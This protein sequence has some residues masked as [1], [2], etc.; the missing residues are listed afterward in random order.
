MTETSGFRRAVVVAEQ[1]GK[2]EARRSSCRMV[3]G[4]RL[5]DLDHYAPALIAILN[6]RLSAGASKLYRRSFRLGIVD[7]RVLA[8][9]AIESPIPAARVAAVTGTDKAAVSRALVKLRKQ[10]CVRF[11]AATS[12]PRR[13]RWRLSTAGAKLHERI[14]DVALR[15]EA[16]LLTGL[17]TREIETFNA[18]ARRMI[19]N[20]PLLEPVT[21]LSGEGSGDDGLGT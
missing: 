2:P 7:W 19:R 14:L 10:G 3:D 16:L 13:K 6:N 18:L 9:L 21:H 20:L 15:R 5:L 12:D 8:M 11:R 4:R 17:S 1:P